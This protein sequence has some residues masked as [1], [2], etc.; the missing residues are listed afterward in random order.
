MWTPPGFDAERAEPYPVLYLQHGGGQSYRDWVEVG[1]AAQI[2]DNLHADGAIQPMV[3]VMGNG[4]VPSF[5]D[6]LFRIARAAERRY[7][8]SS[9]PAQRALAGLSMGGGQTFDVLVS[10]P[11]AFSHVGTFGAGRFNH[12]DD[13]PAD[14]INEGTELLRLYVGN[15][16]DIAYNDVHH[17]MQ[18]LDAAGVEYQFDGA[19]PDAGHN[20]DAWQEN[21]VD[22][23]QRLFQDGRYPGM[24]PGHTAIDAPFE[25]PASGT[26][27]TPWVSEDGYVTFET[28]T[29]FADAEHVTV[30][31]N[32]GPSNLWLRVEL[33]KAGDRWR[34]TVG[35]LEPGWYHY[36][37]IVD[38]VST[39]DTGNPTS[40]TTEPTW[41]Q[42]FVPGESARLVAPVPEGEGGTIQPMEY[43]SEV[44]GE[45]RTALVWTPPGYDADRAEPYPVF[46]LQH[47]GGQRYTDWSEMGQAKNILDN[48]L[49]DGNL[50]P[51]V[52]VMPDGNVTDYTAELLENVVPATEAQFNVSDDPSRRALAGLSRG[53]GQTMG[54]LTQ[55]PGD[56]AYIGA[57]SGGLGGDGSALDVDAINEGTTLLRLYNGNVTD[58]TYAG[59][60]NTMATFDRLGVRYEF[61]GWYEGPHGWDTWQYALADF[62]PRLFRDATAHDSE[63]IAIDVTVPEVAEGFLSM[64]VA[65]YGDSATLG[66]ARNAGDRLVAGGEL[67]TITV[68]DSRTDQQ[69]GDSGWAV[70]GQSSAL[71]AAGRTIEAHHVGWTPMLVEPRDGVRVGAPVPTIMSG[72]TGLSTPQR[73]VEAEG[74]GRHG[75]VTAKAGLQLEVPVDTDPGTYTGAVTVSLFPVD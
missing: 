69:A 44:T 39:K 9:D 2:F 73:L 66:E 16:T 34:G 13:L 54:V 49:R 32:W 17:A 62:A 53:A 41:S 24:S 37:L 8:V 64:T 71:V 51:M 43:H 26:T 18:K 60:V 59:V 50:E 38:M 70:S 22:F 29:D 74:D 46:F 27:P 45:E 57:F 7:N 40:V 6:E 3:V 11:G 58:F 48:H 5:T 19:N 12:L 65:E 25:T 72:G 15:P 61:E 63:E 23:A 28:T 42:F 30:W 47:G 14:E 56:F 33:G 31:A 67:P 36:R 52:V 1:R 75:S 10:E 21:L 35:P 20:W 55:R 68:T 4:N